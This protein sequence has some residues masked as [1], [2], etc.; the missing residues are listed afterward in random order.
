VGL[1]A[2]DGRRLRRRGKR[3][4]R[5]PGE[6]QKSAEQHRQFAPEACGQTTHRGLAWVWLSAVGGQGRVRY[7]RLGKVLNPGDAGASIPAAIVQATLAA[8]VDVVPAT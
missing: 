5:Y 1:D 3:T 2:Q 4:C 7:G 6:Q 8:A